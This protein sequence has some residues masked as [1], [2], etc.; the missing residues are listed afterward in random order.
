MLQLSKQLELHSSSYI[1]TVAT[2]AE[3]GL[4]TQK[5]ISPRLIDL[6]AAS[7]V[8][9]VQR[10]LANFTRGVTTSCES[11]NGLYQ[12]KFDVGMLNTVKN[13]LADVSS[14]TFVERRAAW[15]VVRDECDGA[16]WLVEETTCQSGSFQLNVQ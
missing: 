15:Y 11:N 5:H 3:T 12:L 6:E 9:D 8:E 13:D 7:S 14:A 16:V 10:H 1:A 2:D 4:S